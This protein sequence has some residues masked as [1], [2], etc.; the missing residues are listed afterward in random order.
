MKNP[1]LEINKPNS[2]FNVRLVGESHSL[3]LYWGRDTQGRYLFI[4][5]TAT[6][7]IPEKKNLPK[8]SGVTTAIATAGANSKLFLMLNETSNWELFHALC[9]D[10]VRATSTVDDPQAAGVIFLRRLTR[11]QEFLKHERSGILPVE[12]IKGLIGE[13]LFLSE[14]LAISFEWDEAISFWKGPEDAPQ[15][16]AIHETAVEVKCQSGGS[17]PSVRITS[18]EQLEPQLPDGYLAVYTLSSAD[19]EDSSGFNLN[20]LI[21]QIRSQLEGSSEAARERF[22]DLLF[23]AGYIY[24]D[25]YDRYRYAKIALRCYKIEEEFPR[26]RISHISSGIERITYTL[27]LEACAPFQNQ[28][29]W[30]KE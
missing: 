9:S 30:W 15:D 8:L 4:L 12:A 3:R 18:V 6:A 7:D 29:T 16:F 24:S 2:D 23:M 14:K 17:K 10:L 19:K 11:W 20:S 22:E 27:K 5:D 26:I 28:P 1:W 25:E 13:L 21:A